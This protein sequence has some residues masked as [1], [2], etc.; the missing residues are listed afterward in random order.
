MS[1]TQIPES[2]W[3]VENHLRVGWNIRDA[4]G[5]VPCVAHV[6]GSRAVADLI[7]AAP[8]LLAALEAVQAGTKGWG[9]LVDAA[10]AKAKGESVCIEG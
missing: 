9:T 6:Y 7:A 5:N 3:T 10:L 8:D 1:E 4:G 2:P